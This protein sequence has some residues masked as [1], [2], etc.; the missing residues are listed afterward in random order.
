MRRRPFQP[1]FQTTLPIQRFLIQKEWAPQSLAASLQVTANALR[2]ALGPPSPA[3][4][5]ILPAAHPSGPILP[6]PLTKRV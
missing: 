2:Q 4:L 6:R 3:G 1:P 5:T